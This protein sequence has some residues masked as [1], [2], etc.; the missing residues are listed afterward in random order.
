[1]KTTDYL[2]N[3]R[4]FII[5]RN[6]NSVSSV[7]NTGKHSCRLDEFLPI[8]VCPFLL[9]TLIPYI[10]VLAKGG[11]FTWMVLE[12][13]NSVVVQCPNPMGAVV[14]RLIRKNVDGKISLFISIESVGG[15]CPFA[16]SQGQNIDIPEYTIYE[17][18][19]QIFD[20]VFPWVCYGMITKT[21]F[22]LA[23]QMPFTSNDQSGLFYLCHENGINP[24]NDSLDVCSPDRKA[25][26]TL[27]KYEYRCRY[28]KFP[29][30]DKYDEN[31]LSTPGL[32]IDLFHAAYPWCLLKLYESGLEIVEDR[33]VYIINCPNPDIEVKLAVSKT[34]A[35]G[36]KVWLK[37]MELLRMFNKNTEIPFYRIS[38]EVVKGSQKCPRGHFKGQRFEFN[39]GFRRSMCPASFDNIYPF[40]HSVLRGA[41]SIEEMRRRFGGFLIQCP[42]AYSKNAYEVSLKG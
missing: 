9:H 38:M 7:Q 25:T 8:Q 27:R 5:E 42:D 20:T 10:I 6:I 18:H 41:C 15:A 14:C 32:C 36:A 19:Y 40:M 11:V 3:L 24:D 1:M 17:E 39:L 31:M 28:H 12:D 22:R 26:V 2:P 30:R 23:L 16:H 35:R 21:H 37:V 4:D 33:N 29:K 13:S 34:P